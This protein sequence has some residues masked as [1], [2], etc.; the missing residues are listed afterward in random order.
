M[1][2]KVKTTITSKPF[3]A[4]VLIVITVIAL[5]IC[6]FIQKQPE[7]Q[8]QPTTVSEAESLEESI[9]EVEEQRPVVESSIVE[10]TQ[11]LETQTIETESVT[12][13]TESA[14]EIESTTMETKEKEIK[15]EV[16]VTEPVEVPKPQEPEVPEGGQPGQ[17]YDP[18]FGWV[19]PSDS[20][21]TQSGSDGDINKP[22]GNM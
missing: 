22:V 11:E 5:V 19:T 12:V 6:Y 9:E 17:V 14:V 20:I 4:I 3:L 7:E 13:E 21:G 10:E 18:A 2:D 8:F 15:E 1:E 16:P